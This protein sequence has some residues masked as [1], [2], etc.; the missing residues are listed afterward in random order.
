MLNS[1]YRIASLAV[2]FFLSQLCGHFL[3]PAP[4]AHA[5]SA[6]EVTTIQDT[7][8]NGW[9]AFHKGDL[10]QAVSD[11]LKAAHAYQAAGKVS[12]QIEVLTFLGQAYQSLGEYKDSLKSLAI[13]LVLAEK[14]QDRAQLATV[15]GGLGN[16][17]IATGP[18]EKAQHYL[19]ESLGLA[20]EI[21]NPELSAVVLNNLGNFLASQQKF[22]DALQAYSESARLA[23]ET[24]KTLLETETLT[25]AAMVSLLDGQYQ[26]AKGL[27]ETVHT[28]TR[29]LAPSNQK[30]YALI[31]IG[32]TYNDLRHHLPEMTGPLLTSAANSLNEALVIAEQINDRRG[33]SFALGYLG[34]L[35]EETGRYD[36][37]LQLTRKAVFV[38]QQVNAPE[39]LY[40]WQ[41]Q[42]ARL[43]KKVGDIENSLAA[44]RRAV[45][46]LES[47][48]KGVSN[49]YG[50]NRSSFRESIGPLYFELVDLLLRR[51]AAFTNREQY[52][53]LLMEARA[54]V[55]L[56]KA[57]ELRDY[58]RDD[59][60]DAARS[61]VTKL[62]AVTQTAA[63]I[64]PIMLPDRLELLV[65]LPGGL[66][67][68]S[69]PV[70]A[71][72]L[73]QEVRQFRSKLEK[74]TTREY[75]PHA[76]KL[77]DWLVRPLEPE[78]KSLKADTLVFVPDG[79][80][81]TIPMAALHDGNQFL[82]SK[83]PVA[84]TPG[85]DLTDPRPLKRE[86]VKVLAAG[87]TAAVQGFPPLPHVSA[88]IGA[89]Q[90]LYGA[91]RLLNQEFVAPKVQKELHDSHFN[92]VHI[93]SHG[94]FSGDVDKTFLLTFDDKLTVDR[95]DQYVGL[96]RF[97]DDPLELLTLS[98]CETAAGDDR[99]ALGLAGIAIKA[100]ARSAL[101]S[102]WFINDSATATLITEFYRQLQNP[103]VS[104]AVALQ[105]A[106]LLLLNDRVYQH[107]GYWSSFLLI[108]NWL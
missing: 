62:D 19:N 97:R 92:V 51:S 72:T 102:L 69:V 13:A 85:L 36:D 107:P 67:R 14:S 68:V 60:V 59:C 31:N 76:Q 8:E 21:P 35:Y 105:R 10:D 61:R 79:P 50:V 23:K 100:G 56:F 74:R 66:R 108:N 28:I 29:G 82:I 81:R 101:A 12:E 16:L 3:S 33:A 44:Y 80:L 88:E 70:T 63:V 4:I 5:Q 25:N 39:S 98:A 78:F 9:A 20:R 47:V 49:G 99:A 103:S 106:Q 38:A 37:A 65:T 53:P 48:R 104:R 41:W 42:S 77:Y 87:L 86:N 73:T 30:L 24:S 57:A 18:A 83:Y 46:T 94:E 22:K 64:Y 26:S 32:I 58:F 11:W 91:D 7:V 52:E 54:T 43:L 2:V 95:L 45:K 84:V 93:A 55:E 15:M 6:S 96:F 40:R 27:L 17:Y 90:D 89:L 71:E 75:L 1:A 34:Q